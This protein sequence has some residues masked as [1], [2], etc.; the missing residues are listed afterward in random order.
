MDGAALV[1]TEFLAAHGGAAPFVALAL[2]IAETVAFLSVFIPATALLMAAGAL[3]ATGAFPFLPLWA[4]AAAGAVIGSTFSWWL[5]RRFG[6]RILAARILRAN[7][8]AVARAQALF[9]RGGAFHRPVAA[10]RV[11][12]CGHV[13]R[14]LLALSVLEHP[15]RGRLGLRHSPDRGARRRPRGLVPAV[16]RP[17]IASGAG[18][19]APATP[20]PTSPPHRR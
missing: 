3:T 16:P 5:G 7:A 2:A 4:G 8:E 18:R 15:R 12:V 9:D 14:G 13:G 17:L 20:I 10:G 1:V 6:P 11:P 19:D